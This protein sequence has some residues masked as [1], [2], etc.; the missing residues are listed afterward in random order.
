MKKYKK[1]SANVLKNLLGSKSLYQKVTVSN[2]FE[3]IFAKLDK[4]G[5][6]KEK[7][8]SITYRKNS[9]ACNNEIFIGCSLFKRSFN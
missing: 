6:I 4:T 3:T 9:Q 7:E 8:V 2:D 5:R 1:L